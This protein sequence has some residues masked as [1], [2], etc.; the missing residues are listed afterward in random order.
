MVVV[1]NNST[2]CN[3]TPY[4]TL[5]ILYII[6]YTVYHILYMYILPIQHTYIWKAPVNIGS[7]CKNNSAIIYKLNA[8]TGL[9]YNV[10]PLLSTSILF[11]E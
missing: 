5:H 10:F 7:L 8:S 4:T 1:Y 2:V 3:S 6:S 9:I 11:C